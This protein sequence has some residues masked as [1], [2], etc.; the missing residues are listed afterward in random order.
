MR[1]TVLPSMLEILTRNYNY[2]NQNV[3]LYEVGRIYLPGGKDGLANEAKIVSLGAY[4]SDMDFYTMK[5]AI[6]AI[7]KD[8]RAEDISFFRTGSGAP[9]ENS[10]HPGRYATVWTRRRVCLGC[11]RPDPPL[12]WLRHYGVDY[13]ALLPP[14]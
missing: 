11:A 2:R 3:K 5:G 7:L 1:T 8:L 12:W 6:E 4:G 14:S 10:Y 9:T 13:R